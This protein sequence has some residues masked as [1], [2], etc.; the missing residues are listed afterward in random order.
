[1]LFSVLKSHH[2]K[3]LGQA[4]LTPKGQSAWSI[5]RPDSTSVAHVRNLQHH[6]SGYIPARLD[7]HLTVNVTSQP[8]ICVARVL[9][10]I[11]H[12][13]AAGLDQASAA[14]GNVK[15]GHSATSICLQA[16]RCSS[17]RPSPT[18][19]L[20][21]TFSNRPSP[22][23]LLQPTFSNRPSPT[24]LLQPTFIMNH[25]MSVRGSVSVSRLPPAAALSASVLWSSRLFSSDYRKGQDN[26]DPFADNL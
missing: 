17:D 11:C 8:E 26:V 4:S 10:W 18:D 15:L 2:G 1:M 24:D 6:S 16:I 19:L 20:Q 12:I 21:P 3:P 23:D 7:A 9:P 22:T 5:R 25:C 13:L 14:F